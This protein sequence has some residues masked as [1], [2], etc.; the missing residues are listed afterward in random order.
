VTTLRFEG[1]QPGERPRCTLVFELDDER[2]ER[3]LAALYPTLP[4]AGAAAADPAQPAAPLL[5]DRVTVTFGNGLATPSPRERQQSALDLLKSAGAQAPAAS[6]PPAG[7]LLDAMGARL[8]RIR[9]ALIALRENLDADHD[10]AA[11]KYAQDVDEIIAI[12]ADAGIQSA[13]ALGTEYLVGVAEPVPTITGDQ[14]LASVRTGE[15]FTVPSP[16]PVSSFKVVGVVPAEQQVTPAP[17]QPVIE[18][19]TLTKAQAQSCRLGD[20]ISVPLTCAHPSHLFD[21]CAP[22][23]RCGAR[24]VMACEAC[25]GSGQAWAPHPC[26]HCEGSGYTDHEGFAIR[27]P[28]APQ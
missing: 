18:L 8:S 16:M 26:G 2:A 9:V 4:A 28:R 5:G 20:V 22:T 23:C 24:R 3:I 17:E 7:P 11:S 12:A 27:L 21:P 14:M 1:L 15:R 13:G 19:P 6:G 10:D 25:K